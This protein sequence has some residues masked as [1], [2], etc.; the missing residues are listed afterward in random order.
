VRVSQNR[1]I[2]LHAVG[3]SFLASATAFIFGFLSFALDDLIIL[4]MGSDPEP[5][6][7]VLINYGKCTI[8]IGNPA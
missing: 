1:G 4:G 3:G 2:A 8:G 7:G 5:D 6:C